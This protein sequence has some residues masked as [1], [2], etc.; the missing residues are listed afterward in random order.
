MLDTSS[1]GIRFNS[2]VVTSFEPS[3]SDLNSLYTPSV[4]IDPAVSPAVARHRLL[5]LVY[6][7]QMSTPV[8]LDLL[9]ILSEVPIQDLFSLEPSVSNKIDGFISHSTLQ[10]PL[11]IEPMSTSSEAPSVT[12]FGVFGALVPHL[13]QSSTASDSNAG[14]TTSILDQRLVGLVERILLNNDA[15]FRSAVLT[16]AEI[17]SAGSVDTSSSPEAALDQEL[18]L[19]LQFQRVIDRIDSNEGKWTPLTLQVEKVPST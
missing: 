19:R 15:Q 7:K 10:A 8:A 6:D 1:D 11:E 3:E 4:G 13:I 5:D 12:H 14:Q 18:R 2:E 17:L 16:A 9:G